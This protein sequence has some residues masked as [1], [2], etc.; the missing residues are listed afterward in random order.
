MTPPESPDP[1]T[2]R[3]SSTGEFKALAHP[4]RL[5]LLGALRA[6]GPDTSAGLARRLGT[7]TG[8]TSYHL[9][10]LAEAGFIEDDPSTDGRERRWRAAHQ[11]TD[12]DSTALAATAE[13]REAM[14]L[15][16]NQQVGNLQRDISQFQ[17]HIADVP[18][19]WIEA[20]GIGDLLIR[21]SP[22]AVTELWDRFYAHAE[23]L[24]EREAANP[25]AVPVSIVV[26][27]Y[28]RLEGWE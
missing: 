23:E 14:H 10:K 17:H 22:E 21:L 16:R 24:R 25:A 18:A 12:W 27:G 9:R 11:L 2:R 20:A 8:T 4:I 3:V 6:H 5:S 19:E 15:L 7:D 1:R 13:G 26:S 28:P